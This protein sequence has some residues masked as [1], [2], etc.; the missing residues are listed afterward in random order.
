MREN[1]LLVRHTVRWA[2]AAPSAPHVRADLLHTVLEVHT[3][4]GRPAVLWPTGS[5]EAVVRVLWPDSQGVPAAEQSVMVNTL[6]AFWF[7]L[8]DTGRMAPGSAAPEDLAREI[9][10]YVRTERSRPAPLEP[11]KS[12]AEL[13]E[14]LAAIQPGSAHR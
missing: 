3:G 6:A 9:W 12:L 7:F 10:R 4:E 2:A 8:R 14:K 5:A 13:M 1:Q 11:R